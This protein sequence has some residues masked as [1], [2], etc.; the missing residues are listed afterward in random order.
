MQRPVAAGRVRCK[1]NSSHELITFLVYGHQNK[2]RFVEG[3]RGLKY[4]GYTGPCSFECGVHGDPLVEIPKSLDFLR[5][6]WE[7]AII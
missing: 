5:K 3:F 2:S 7:L 4:I 1:V 6:E